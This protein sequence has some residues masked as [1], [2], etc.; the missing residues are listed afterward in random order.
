MCKV[1]MLKALV[2]R[3]LTEAA[4]EIIG[5]FERTITEYED[6]L[7][8]SKEENEKQRQL[9]DTFLKPRVQVYVEDIQQPTDRKKE[10]IPEQHE[11]TNIAEVHEKTEPYYIKVEDQWTNQEGESGSNAV[12]DMK[13]SNSDSKPSQYTREP[14]LRTN[15]LTSETDEPHQEASQPYSCFDLLPD[16]LTSDSSHQVPQSNTHFQLQGNVKQFQCIDCGKTYKSRASLKRHTMTHTGEKPHKCS[17]CGKKFMQRS[18]LVMHS[19]CHTGVKP[20][21]CTLC[22]WK[23][24]KKSSLVLH[25]RRH[26]GEKPHWCSVC[27]KR[28]R[29]PS[30]LA[31]HSRIHIK[32]NVY[33]CSVCS[34]GF[35]G[36]RGLVAHRKSH[37]REQVLSCS[38]CGKEVSSSSYL[39]LHMRIHTGEKIPFEEESKVRTNSTVSQTQTDI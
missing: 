2:A 7:C 21:A 30:S 11:R 32:G 4:D 6:E 31:E 24:S 25:M 27:G 29:H 1:R 12:D 14:A 3:R 28:F 39:A 17:V 36:K 18:D 23:F 15:N 20:F 22:C 13:S 35:P 5:I 16:Q 9:L 33:S 34:A 38:R 10:I 19:R 26:T 37:S 8:R